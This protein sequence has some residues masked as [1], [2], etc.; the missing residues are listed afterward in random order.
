MKV[1]LLYS[2]NEI[3]KELEHRIN[4]HGAIQ[5]GETVKSIKAALIANG[6]E[7]LLIQADI[8]LPEK[9]SNM[10]DVDII[11]NVSTGITKKSQQAHVVAI[12]E[13]M[14]IPFVGSGLS[15]QI[16]GIQKHITKNI[17]VSEGIPTPKF[18]V[19]YNGEEELKN[20]LIFPLILKPVHEGSSMG[21]T[22]ESIVFDEQSFRNRV[23][24]LIKDF[25]QAA[26]AEE[27]IVGREF[28]IGIIGN[29]NPEVLPIEEIIFDSRDTSKLGVMTL[30]IK[31]R[32][33]I[34]PKTPAELDENIANKMRMYALRA[35]KALGCRD[36]IRLD[37]RMDENNVPYFLEI[38]T[39]PGLQPEYSEFPRMSLAAG[40]KYEELIEKLLSVAHK[41]Y[42]KNK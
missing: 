15:A 19:F 28:T 38:N 41:R 37:V 13:M 11:F 1:G 27:F 40:Y 12:L 22:D 2:K 25:K 23:K 9:L 36:F 8:D 5:M 26:M 32:D 14:G 29:D 4:P 6:H 34:V 33:A 20:S 10:I 3:D 17:F 30:D 39:L 18:Q 35:F 16:L 21:I 42:S 24:E 31:T 7:V